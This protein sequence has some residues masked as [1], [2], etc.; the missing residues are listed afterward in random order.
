MKDIISS[1]NNGFNVV[2]SIAPLPASPKYVPLKKAMLYMK[3]NILGIIIYL[4]A[5][6]LGRFF[7]LYIKNG[8]KDIKPNKNLKK[9]R[10]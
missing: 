3:N 2:T 5:L 10:L 7:L 6:R 4:Y 9:M 8:S 1:V